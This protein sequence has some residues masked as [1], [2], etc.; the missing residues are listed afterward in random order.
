MVSVLFLPFIAFA[1]VAQDCKTVTGSGLSG[2]FLCA[3]GIIG[4]IIGLIILGAF[5]F[6]LWGVMVFMKKAD[7]QTKR[8]E[9]RWFMIWGTFALFMMVAVWGLVQILS[10]TFGLPTAT[11]QNKTGNQQQAPLF[12][13]QRRI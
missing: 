1:D 4:Y 5:M 2:L 13:G 6:F 8:A 12:D 11:P 10:N 7:D 3:S 9:G